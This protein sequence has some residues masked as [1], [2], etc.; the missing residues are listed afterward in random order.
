MKGEP[1]GDVLQ[2]GLIVIDA[3][4]GEVLMVSPYL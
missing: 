3:R 4:A 2:G 1:E